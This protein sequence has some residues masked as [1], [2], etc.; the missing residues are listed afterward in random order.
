MSGHISGTLVKDVPLHIFLDSDIVTPNY[1][2]V[3]LHRDDLYLKPEIWKE[4]NDMFK[5]TIR[6]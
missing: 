2:I 5:Q 4:Y 3:L 6:I 1:L